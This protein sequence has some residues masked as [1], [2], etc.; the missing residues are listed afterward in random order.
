M[1]GGNNTP[2]TPLINTLVTMYVNTAIDPLTEANI[3]DN[4][5]FADTNGDIT[6]DND[7]QGNVSN[8][9]TMVTGQ[10]NITWVGAVQDIR[11]NPNDYVL[12]TDVVIKP[13]NP[14]KISISKEPSPSQ[15][16][17]NNTH[18]SG[19]VTGNHNLTPFGYTIKFTVGRVDSS[20]NRT[21]S[22]E[23]NID[24]RIQIN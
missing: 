21:T 23:L 18:V 3:K 16:I 9:T 5:W 20:G 6:D 17:G 22:N 1:S 7:N 14:G 10:G 4:V 19:R 15:G 11:N 24:P 12:I 8:Y 2:A 13:G